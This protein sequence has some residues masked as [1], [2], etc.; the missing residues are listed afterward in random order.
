[1]V[2]G[3]INGGSIPSGG[4]C[5]SLIKI[6]MTQIRLPIKK[7][8]SSG[9]A[10]YKIEAENVYWLIGEHSGYNKWVLPKGM[11]EA[12]ETAIE[13]AVREV[14]EEMGVRA[15]VV[16][17][18]PIHTE[19]YWF[20]AEYS[21]LHHNQKPLRRV[22][23]YAENL[24]KQNQAQ[25]RVKVF[26]TVTFFLM[27]F[28]SGGTEDHDFEMNHVGWYSFLE[29]LDKL[30]FTG[31]KLALKKAHDKIIRPKDGGVA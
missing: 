1:M 18:E 15:K 9:G 8:F 31:E 29:A 5:Y 17:T 25:D 10:V 20:V 16:E 23:T 6:D 12:G 22:K 19:K 2:S 27:E 7:E 3:T 26:K 28:Q 14:A 4:T 11:I 30:A 21:K 13:A 24:E